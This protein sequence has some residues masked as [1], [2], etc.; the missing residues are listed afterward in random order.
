MQVI[1]FEKKPRKSAALFYSKASR[2]P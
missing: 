2:I 1:T